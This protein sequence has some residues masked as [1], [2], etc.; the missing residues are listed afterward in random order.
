MCRRVDEVWTIVCLSAL[1]MLVGC[2]PGERSTSG[3]S[4]EEGSGD[5]VG[6]DD[7]STVVVD[8]NPETG[9]YVVTGDGEG[10]VEVGDGCLD[11]EQARQEAEDD[12]CQDPDARADV[13]V[14]DGEVVEVVCYPPKEEG[15]N[16]EEVGESEEGEGGDTEIPQTENGSVVTFDEATNGEPI[17]G[18]VTVDSERTTIYGNGVDET[19]IGGTLTVE[20]NNSRVRSLTVRGDVEYEEASNDSALAYCKIHGSLEVDSNN[21]KG[22]NCR[23]F[24][25]VSVEGNG[26]RLVNIGVGGEWEV[27]PNADCQGCYSFDDSNDDNTVQDDEIGEDLACGGREGGP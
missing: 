26:A 15:T 12:Y 22:M 6:Y 9:D 24:G 1:A 18:D 21:F 19:I 17:E 7:G 8:D 27:N 3:W 23:V 10:C 14:E 2:G 4:V 25:D 16:I 13:V 5:E 20:S 11:P